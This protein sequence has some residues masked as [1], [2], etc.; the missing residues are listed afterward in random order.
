[1]SRILRNFIYS[2]IILTFILPIGANI[3]YNTYIANRISVNTGPV[4]NGNRNSTE[5]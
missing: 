2:G 3:G 4:I 5:K 1:M